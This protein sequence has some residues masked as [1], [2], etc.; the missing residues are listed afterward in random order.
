[1]QLPE[2]LNAIRE[3]CEERVCNF[4]Y[5]QGVQWA[6]KHMS[7]EQLAA[8]SKAYAAGGDDIDMNIAI[9]LG[10]SELVEY[11]ALSDEESIAFV[12]GVVDSERFSVR[13]LSTVGRPPHRPLP[14]PP[15]PVTLAR[16]SEI[17]CGIA[18]KFKTRG[19]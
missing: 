9:A 12:D 2:Y 6:L 3:K 16:F 8:V 1:M 15:I 14:E 13:L 10:T 19:G 18:P 17:Q 5:F 7:P 11:L 4:T